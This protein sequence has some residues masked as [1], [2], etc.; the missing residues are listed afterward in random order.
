MQ[1]IQAKI[2]LGNIRS[3]AEFFSALTGKKLCAVVKANAYGHGAV[4][5][6]NALEG[7]A[8]CFAV[9]ILSEAME[10]RLPACGKDIL[11]FTPPL[12]EEEAFAFIDNNF[13]VT[14]SGL[15]TAQL[16]A[17]ACKKRQKAVR[18]HL[19]INTGMNRYGVDVE[20]L[21]MLCT[22]IRQEPYLQVEGIYTHLY[23]MNLRTAYRQKTLFE[24]AISSAKAYFPVLTAHIGGTYGAL[25]GRDFSFDMTR[26]GLGLYGYLPDGAEDMR[27]VP[28]LRKAMTVFAQVIE[29]RTY[30][31]GDAGYGK[32]N[33]P[34]NIGD[35][36]CVCRYGYADGF[37]RT[38]KN[39][40]TNADTQI[41]NLCMDACVRKEQYEQGTWIPVMIDAAKVAKDTGTI[42]YEVLCAA[43]KRAEFVYN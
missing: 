3:N 40:V 41:N 4:E 34:L 22:F 7:V 11:V 16:L 1:K 5:V 25:L 26:V 36:L 42:S 35:E 2:Y 29:N 30:A 9:A 13:V 17:N 10:I 21:S 28:T 12:T 39:G 6:V 31:F 32:L 23:D 37:L 20:N 33:A 43:T 19:K 27:N 14:V 15:T 38:Q 18:V 8:D 24:R